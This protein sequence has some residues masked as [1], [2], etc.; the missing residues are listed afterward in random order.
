MRFKTRVVVGLQVNPGQVCLDCESKADQI[1]NQREEVGK[2][3][4]Q[5]ELFSFGDLWQFY[6]Y[7][8]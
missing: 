8:R 5:E 2:G 4:E 1:R 6:R 3:A 7:H